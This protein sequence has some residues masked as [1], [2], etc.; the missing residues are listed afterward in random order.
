MNA[1]VTNY[2]NRSWF[3]EP[4][5]TITNPA[6]DIQLQYDESDFTTDGSLG[7]DDI[8]PVKISSGGTWYQPIDG[9]FTNAS[10]EGFDG[11]TDPDQNLLRW[12]DLQSFSEFGGAG[13]SNQPLPVELVSFSGN[14]ENGQVNLSWQ[15]A[16]EFNSSHF[17]IEKSRDGENWQVIETIQASGNSNE[18]LNYEAFDQVTNI[19]NYYRL[20]QVD[21]DGTNKRYDPIAVS[22]EEA[23]SGLF[24]T[25]PNPS[26][27]GFNVLVND[28]DMV[29]KMSM[30]IYTA[31]GSLTM[32]KIVEV[33]EGINVFMI[34]DKILPGLYFIELK[35]QN[36]KTKVIKHLI[37]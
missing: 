31:P 27:N 7:E 16:S 28:E 15:T 33:K 20:N 13:G 2:I 21:I 34:H 1:N 8:I 35:D 32:N 37:N 12:N 29:G 18:L 14:C 24:M 4:T 22:C 23:Q 6:Y 36:N 25:Y 5:G 3:V 26:A 30:N 9:S 17:D 19:L 11:I 10:E